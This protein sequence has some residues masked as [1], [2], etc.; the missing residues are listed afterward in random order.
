[1]C[2][3]PKGW[4]QSHPELAPQHWLQPEAQRDAQAVGPATCDDA[5]AQSPGTPQAHAAAVVSG[6]LHHMTA[7]KSVEQDPRG[8]GV[9]FLWC[10]T[11][12]SVV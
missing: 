12:R 10:Q 1:M 8:L 4:M 11:D 2:L 3:T 5:G 7:C 6:L 9:W